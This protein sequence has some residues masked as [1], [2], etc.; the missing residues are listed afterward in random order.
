ML[1]AWGEAYGQLASIFIKT[2]EDTYSHN[3]STPGGWRG[4]R[5]CVIRDI[6]DEASG[7]KSV[8]LQ[9]EDGQLHY[10]VLAPALAHLQGFLATR[11]TS[12]DMP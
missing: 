6:V 9:A 3:A 1:R 11:S 12:A 5:P 10:E 8:Y 4:F 7:I 2:E